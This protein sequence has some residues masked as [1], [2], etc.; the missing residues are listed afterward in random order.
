MIK[1]RAIQRVEQRAVDLINKNGGKCSFDG[2]NGEFEKLPE[3]CQMGDMYGFDGGLSGTCVSRDLEFNGHIVK[4]T[5][6]DTRK[7]GS[8]V[9]YCRSLKVKWINPDLRQMEAVINNS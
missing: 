3:N 9:Q 6:E 2:F 4:M 7:N 1:I 8:P 5:V